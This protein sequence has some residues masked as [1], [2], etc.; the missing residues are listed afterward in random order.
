MSLGISLIL[1]AVMVVIQMV[2]SVSELTEAGAVKV[3]AACGIG[4]VQLL[5]HWHSGEHNPDGSSA[6]GSYK[7]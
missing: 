7:R 3:M 5:L 1:Q 4:V 2:N 6:A